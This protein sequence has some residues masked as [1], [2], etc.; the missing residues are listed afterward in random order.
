MRFRDLERAV[1]HQRDPDRLGPARVLERRLQPRRL[2]L[3]LGVV[4]LV[5]G[6]GEDPHASAS[7]SF[8]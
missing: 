6:R 7:S 4:E 3:V 8:R 1:G 5:P 2:D